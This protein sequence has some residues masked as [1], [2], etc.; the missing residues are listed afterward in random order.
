MAITIRNLKQHVIIGNSS[1]VAISSIPE[2]ATLTGNI[3]SIVTITG[4]PSVPGKLNR[5]PATSEVKPDTNELP[6]TEFIPNKVYLIISRADTVF[7]YTINGLDDCPAGSLPAELLNNP[8]ITDKFQYI[9]F[10]GTDAGGSAKA[11]ASPNIP[12]QWYMCS[13]PPPSGP[14]YTTTLTLDAVNRLEQ[15]ESLKSITG[16]YAY[17]SSNVTIVQSRGSFPTF[18]PWNTARTYSLKSFDLHTSFPYP[19]E[20]YPF[21]LYRIETRTDT[22]GSYYLWMPPTPTPTPTPTNTVTPTITPTV[23]PTVTVTETPTVTPTVTTTVTPTNTL[24]PTATPT[25]TRTPTSTPT[26]GAPPTSTPTQTPTV[27]PT[28]TLTP[29]NTPTNSQTPTVTKTVEPA[30]TPSQT[31]TVTKTVEPTSTPPQTPTVTKT[32]EPTSTPQST[33]TQTPTPTVTSF[34]GGNCGVEIEEDMLPGTTRVREIFVGTAIG[35]IDFTYDNILP[36][37]YVITFDGIVVLDTGVVTSPGTMSFIKN[38]ATTK[39]YVTVYAL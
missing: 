21:K 7:P 31:P 18:C 29:T 36:Y 37:R 28:L 2:C 11:A 15:I 4:T 16:N 9:L 10:D 22:T 14:P 20:P 34:Y 17:N 27:T 13:A 12:E 33:P 1:P 3:V 6:F 24:T 23:T 8:L 30:S 35:L 25:N 19:N 38:T 5:G 32:V 39:A 26:P